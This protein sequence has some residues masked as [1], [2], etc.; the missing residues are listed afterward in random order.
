MYVEVPLE[1]DLLITNTRDD[2]NH[3]MRLQL[4]VFT[5]FNCMKSHKTDV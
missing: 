2:Y 5:Y 3:A 1:I 4:N